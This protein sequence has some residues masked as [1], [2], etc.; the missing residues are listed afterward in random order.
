[1]GLDG[2]AISGRGALA[3]AFKIESLVRTIANS[4]NGQRVGSE[5]VNGQLAGFGEA[6]QYGQRVGSGKVD[7]ANGQRVGL[8]AVNGQLA[9]F[10]E[11]GQYGGKNGQ[12]V[13]MPYGAGNGQLVGVLET[14]EMLSALR[15][16]EA[17]L[18]A[19]RIQDATL[20][21]TVNDLAR[22]VK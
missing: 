4:A 21:R 16:L 3:Q 10:G 22:P 14:A 1:M 2:I 19:L 9:G 13:G 17:N 6:G 18:Q 8:G 11:V 7:V 20:E 5:A 15:A 12:R